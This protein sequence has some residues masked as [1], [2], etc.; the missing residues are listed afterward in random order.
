M[1]FQNFKIKNFKIS[2]FQ[3][4][5][6]NWSSDWSNW[7]SDKWSSDKWSSDIDRDRD[8]DWSSDWSSENGPLGAHGG[9]AD[10]FFYAIFELFSRPGKGSAM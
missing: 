3:T 7:S 10:L 2:R 9:K 1:T 5:S 4:W 8:R 6:S